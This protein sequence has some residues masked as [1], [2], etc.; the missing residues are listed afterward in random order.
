MGR[1]R[2]SKEVN[3]FQP[4]PQGP[5][6]AVAVI[7]D[8]TLTENDGAF[9]RLIKFVSGDLSEQWAAAKLLQNRQTVAGEC[10]AGSGPRGVAFVL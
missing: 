5:Y 1:I 4:K 3:P 10:R 7:V 9:C 2:K 6:I 8:R